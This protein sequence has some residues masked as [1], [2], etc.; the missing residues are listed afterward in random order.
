MP[1]FR[2][3]IRSNFHRT[4]ELFARQMKG[5]IMD[6][7]DTEPFDWSELDGKTLLVK[8]KETEDGHFVLGMDINDPEQFYVLHWDLPKE[9]CHEG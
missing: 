7:F 9:D 8:T 3:Y 5:I 1:W 6:E 4:N 2:F